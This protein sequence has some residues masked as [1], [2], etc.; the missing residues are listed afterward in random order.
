MRILVTG[1]AGFIGSHLV[2]A[3]A[4]GPDEIVGIDNLRRGDVARLEP[5]L[6]AKRIQFR[7]AD[8]RDTAA[9]AEVIRD[10]SV[11]YH[12]AAQSNVLGAMSDPDYSFTTNVTGTDNVLKAASEAGAMRVVFSSSREVYGEPASLPVAEDA[13]LKPKNLYGASKAAGEAY[14]RAWADVGKV[15]VQVLRFANVYGTRDTGRVIPLW[16]DAATKDE[17]LVLYGGEQVL[18]F[19]WIGTAVDALISAGE[20]QA[21]EPI[22]VGSG[23]GTRLADLAQRII[24]AM[25]SRSSV[26]REPARSVEVERFIADVSRMRQH[27]HMEPLADPLQRLDVLT[28]VAEAR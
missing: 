26:R 2:D 1:A 22:N 24:T 28:G 14:C 21:G 7:A 25:G 9:L 18:D 27:L 4:E 17:D 19:V 6:K 15:P 16:L 11:V 3:L 8:I 10:V 12:L 23:T 13:A 5:H 20:C